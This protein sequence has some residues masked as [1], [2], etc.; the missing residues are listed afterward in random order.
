MNQ[1]RSSD[2]ALGSRTGVALSSAAAVLTVL[3]WLGHGVSW[4]VPLTC[5]LVC[6]ASFR[7]KQRVT[8]WRQWRGAWNEVAGVAPAKPDAP[9]VKQEPP[10]RIRLRVPRAV[11]IIG[12]FAL[13]PW[14]CAHHSE[15]ATASYGAR[16]V[17]F[18][19]LIAAAAAFRRR[20][21]LPKDNAPAPAAADRG[22]AEHIVAHCLPMPQA[23]PSKHV[24]E[25]L[26]DYCRA[27]LRARPE[28]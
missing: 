28:R 4:L 1:P 12:A 18:L 26:P 5:V 24:R 19:A 22:E 14:M 15:A 20:A 16:T 7:A 8:L 13:L 3:S 21:A 2:F 6:R 17:S 11:L 9:A 23:T 25:L 10:K 27:L